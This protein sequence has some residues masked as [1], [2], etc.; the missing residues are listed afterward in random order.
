MIIWSLSIHFFIYEEMNLN[1]P[2]C[3]RGI[4]QIISLKI[5]PDPSLPKR[6]IQNELSLITMIPFDAP[7][8]RRGASLLSS[9]L[10][11]FHARSF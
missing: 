9:D 6:G 1:T 7:L 2:F 11:F 3:K 4:L 10:I 5:S 8:C